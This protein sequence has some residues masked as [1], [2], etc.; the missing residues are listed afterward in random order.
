MEA[1]C[2][3]RTDALDFQYSTDATSL[4][5]GTW[6]DVDTLD[7]ISKITT[8]SP[9]SLDGNLS[10][11]K[12]LINDTFA[13][14]LAPSSTFWIRWKDRSIT[15]NGDG[16]AVDSVSISANFTPIPEPSSLAFAAIGLGG[17][18]VRLKRRRG[19][20]VAAAAAAE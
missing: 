2:S 6:N 18:F 9:R 8:G 15:G 5:N 16:L 3:G 7:F 20:K 4:A 17:M 19:A 13:L 1:R 12:R 11:N 10:A 14:S